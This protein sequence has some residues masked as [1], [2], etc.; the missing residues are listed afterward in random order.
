ML[1]HL[2]RRWPSIKTT[3]CQR[4]VYAGYITNELEVIF[5]PLLW[6]LFR[7]VL[8]DLY[9]VYTQIL[10]SLDRMILVDFSVNSEPI[11]RQIPTEVKKCKIVLNILKVDY[12][13]CNTILKLI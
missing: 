3:L 10:S 11:S 1:S 6:D 8:L 5:N 9:D 13:T 12:L 2:R 7:T 4:L